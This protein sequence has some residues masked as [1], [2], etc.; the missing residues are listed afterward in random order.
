[1]LRVKDPKKSVPFCASSTACAPTLY[2]PGINAPPSAWSLKGVPE[3]WIAASLTRSP[4]GGADTDMMGMTLLRESHYGDFSLYFLASM[5]EGFK[6]ARQPSS[7]PISSHPSAPM[8]PQHT[9]RS[10]WRPPHHHRKAH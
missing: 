2:L 6:L 9:H 8:M 5:P 10:R 3:I 7:Y 1:M 4:R